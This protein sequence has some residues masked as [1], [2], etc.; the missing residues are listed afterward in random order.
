MGREVFMMLFVLFEIWFVIIELFMVVVLL[1]SLVLIKSRKKLIKFLTWSNMLCE[2]LLMHWKKFRWRLLTIVEC[3]VLNL[4]Q[5]QKQDR[6]K[7]KNPWVGVECNTSTIEDMKQRNVFETLVGKQQ[8]LLLAT[9]VVKM[10]LKI[11]DVIKQGG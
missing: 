4:L 7:K 9:Q 2:V 8:Q 11:D 5:K 10:I 6:L 3:L 1:R